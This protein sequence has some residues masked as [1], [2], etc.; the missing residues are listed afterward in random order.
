MFL[1]I[2][3][4][5][6]FFLFFTINIYA[7][8]LFLYLNVEHNIGYKFEF[9]L[10]KIYFVSIDN[11]IYKFSINKK[12]YSYKAFNQFF[13]KKIK[14]PD[15]HFEK[16]VLEIK[17]KKIEIPLSLK[18]RKNETEALFFVW[19]VKS[20]IKGSNFTPS[21][22]VKN[23]E[24]PLRGELVFVTSKEKN[25]LFFIRVDKNQVCAIMKIES[26]PV[27]MA[28]SCINDRIF[29]LTE[30]SRNINVIEVSLFKKTDLFILPYVIKPEILSKFS[31]TLIVGDKENNRIIS[32]KSDTGALVKSIEIGERISD[33]AISQ[34]NE[35]IVVS[36]YNEQTLYF[37]D[38][39]FNIVKTLKL[40][41]SPYSLFISD[42]MLFVSE[43][44]CN[45]LLKY[46][47]NFTRI[48]KQYRIMSPN[49]VL[50][51][52]SNLYVTDFRKKYLYIFYSNQSSF[53]KK[54]RLSIVP[55]RIS[56]CKRRGWL[57]LSA[58]YSDKIEVVDL[59]LEKSYGIIEL[60]A[61][62]Y[63]IK[64]GRTST[65]CK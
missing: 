51:L 53:S 22:H 33:I 43:P 59:N 31:D 50:F 16:V 6:I 47:I 49:R 29:V 52:D 11:K 34:K 62:P 44:D 13:L 1:R 46:N 58:K 40:N 8:K 12:I 19:D 60:G 41:C 3:Y 35:I 25:A 36:S 56:Y 24:I 28:L 48:E 55:D 14:L 61:K 15:R 65:I 23:Q 63:D 42:D 39:D 37:L 38:K 54:I 4:P 45:F 10:K 64:T 30:K 20:S 5:I 7:S 18:L 32:V 57:Y 9:F 17:N 27:E 2:I 21:I 26:S